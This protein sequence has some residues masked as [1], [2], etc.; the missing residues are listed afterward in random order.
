MKYKL[1]DYAKILFGLMTDSNIESKNLI[2]SFVKLLE[3]KG[4]IKNARKIIGL[5]EKHYLEK[6]GNKKIILETARI[7]NK[8]DFLKIIKKE[9]DI[10][11]EKI[12]PELI[13]G[14][15]ITVNGERQI[16]FSLQK[17]LSE[18]FS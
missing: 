17:K 1:K 11:E 2:S 10:I 18:M 3:K 16:D 7:L 5:A 13:A 15:K 12:N 9:G 8:Q 6:R 4:E 14:V